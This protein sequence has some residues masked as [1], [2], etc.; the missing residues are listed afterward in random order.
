MQAFAPKQKTAPAAHA[1]VDGQ[2][3]EQERRGPQAESLR[4]AVSSQAFDGGS[5]VK[6]GPPINLGRIPLYPPGMG[7]IQTK[8]T[9]NRP[10]DEYEQ[11]ADRVS[12]QIMRMPDSGAAGKSC[13]SGSCGCADCKSKQSEHEPIQ[14]SRAGTV[15]SQTVSVP[16]AV[17]DVLRSAGAPL[18]ASARSFMEPRFGLSFAGI[19]VHTDEKAAES[20]KAIHALAYTRGSHIVFGA[21]KYRPEGWDGRSLLAHELAHTIQQDGSSGSLSGPIFRAPARGPWVTEEAAG[22]CGICYGMM[23]PKPAAEAGKAAHT[24]IQAAALAYFGPYAR[25]EC[26][27]HSPT[28]DNGCL[29]LLVASKD[30]FKIA[31]IKPSNPQGEKDGLRDIRWYKAQ[32]EATYPDKKVELLSERIP[33]GE[34]LLMPDPLAAAAGCAPQRLGVSPMS[35]GV[36]G[37]WCAPP[38]SEARRLCSC[39]KKEREPRRPPIQLPVEKGV[40]VRVSDVHDDFGD[41]PG[42]LPAME[43]PGGRD[44]V[45]MID[46]AL[47]GLAAKQAEA[48]FLARQRRVMQI[49]PRNAPFIQVEP[50][51]LGVAAAWIAAP[52]V[53]ALVTVGLAGLVEAAILAV[54][55]IATAA[56]GAGAA[57]SGVLEWVFGSLSKPIA[58]GVVAS[59]AASGRASRDDATKAIQPYIDK[60]LVAMADVTGSADM[61]KAKLGQEL[62]IGGKNYRS[63]MKLTTRQG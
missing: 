42:R 58:A 6:P 36:Y 46:S 45:L 20:A 29:D 24:A 41:L 21:G 16:A 31:E 32:L 47:F 25:P 22:G 10:G 14:L 26:R 54:D 17:H 49:D 51:L 53:A 39:K 55:A 40:R 43:A 19:R 44:M 59:L 38:F 48:E 8:L 5:V 34:G 28:D 52:I 50:V 61:E 35:L 33:V 37:Y 60:R 4:P 11:E 7:L 18:S 23:S 27:F 30:G 12:G 1:R 13:S 62:S 56:A 57:G 63:I 9:I 2:A 3:L 15:G